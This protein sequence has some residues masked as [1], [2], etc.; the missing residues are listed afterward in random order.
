MARAV[1]CLGAWVIGVCAAIPASAQQQHQSGFIAVTKTQIDPHMAI[2]SDGPP[3]SQAPVQGAGAPGTQENRD[4]GMPLDQ[5]DDSDAG[6]PAGDD[7][8][9][10]NAVETDT[11]YSI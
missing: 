8:F 3:P 2:M 10:D 1:I 9:A 4:N 6:G 11:V 5:S 7:P